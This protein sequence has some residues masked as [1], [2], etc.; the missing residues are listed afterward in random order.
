MNYYEFISDRYLSIYYTHH[1]DGL[2]FNKIPLFRKLKW[3][4]V[5]FVKGVIGTLSEGNKAYSEFPAISYT[6]EYPYW[7]AGIGI[8][9]IF[10]F[11]RVDAVWRLSHL[12][13]DNVFPFGIFF[14]F[15]FI[16]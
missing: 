4:E 7:E 6:L 15:Q 8:E 3:R 1:F 5:A 16:F 11:L 2:L 13:N 10:K 14:S 9:N 12:D